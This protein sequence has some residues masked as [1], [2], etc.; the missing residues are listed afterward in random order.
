[1]HFCKYLN[2]KFLSGMTLPI[3]G[4]CLPA[5]FDGIPKL[6][7]DFC[8]SEHPACISEVIVVEQVAEKR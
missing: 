2:S 5:D 3:L 1:M 4:L 8:T 6:G 7:P